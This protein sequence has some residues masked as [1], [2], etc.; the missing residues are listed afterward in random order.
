MP[1][2]PIRSPRKRSQTD[3]PKGE[4]RAMDSAMSLTRRDAKGLV[5]TR[6]YRAELDPK[7]GRPRR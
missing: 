1:K 5:K 4:R 3:D 6:K 2:K 7:T